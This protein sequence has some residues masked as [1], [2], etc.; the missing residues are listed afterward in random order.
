MEGMI[1]RYSLRSNYQISRVIKGGWQLSDGHSQEIS[2]DPVADMFAFLERGIYTF[3]CADI[4]TGV[5]AMI[6]EFIAANKKRS[7]PFA[8]RVHTKYVP[9]YDQLGSLTKADVEAIIDRSLLRLNLERLDMVQFHWWNYSAPG[10]VEAAMWLK[11][12]QQAGKIELLSTTNF[13][14]DRTRDILNAGV[15]LATTQVQYSLLDPRPE[16]A[17]LSL[18]AE[19]N[20]HLLCYGTLAGGF[21]SERWLDQPEPKA[22]SNRSLI[23]YKLMIDEVGGWDLFQSLLKVLNRIAEK[24]GVTIAS[25]ASNWVLAQA[26]VAAV[27]IGSRNAAHVDRY[28]EVFALQ[29]DDHDRD[30]INNVKAQMSI[31][32]D[33]VFD[34]ERDKN[35]AHGSIMKYNLNAE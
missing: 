32:A 1:E 22:F 9:D 6:G 13:N 10:T 28:K 21:L 27:I 20:M 5:E 31:P 26:Q 29:M 23:K 3:D 18:C 30:A 34:L 25:V 4:Y 14:T 16:K 12:L 35:G 24:H 8:V 15:E 7:S 2:S 11:E 19:H 33:D 17:L